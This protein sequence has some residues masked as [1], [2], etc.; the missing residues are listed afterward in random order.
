VL[1]F[2]IV[3]I[4]MDREGESYVNNEDKEYEQLRYDVLKSFFQTWDLMLGYG[5][6]KF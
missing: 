4:Q 5:S 6:T 3:F 2:A 1:V